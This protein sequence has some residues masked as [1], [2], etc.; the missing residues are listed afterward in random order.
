[1]LAQTGPTIFVIE[2]PLL[3]KERNRVSITRHIRIELSSTAFHNKMLGGEK[4]QQKGWVSVEV[5]R[6]ARAKIAAQ[7]VR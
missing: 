4:L 7:A 2:C 6:P 5:S 3:M 1:L